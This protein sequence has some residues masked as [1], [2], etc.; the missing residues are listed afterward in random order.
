MSSF[1]RAAGKKGEE[2]PCS[3]FVNNDKNEKLQESILGNDISSSNN[4]NS[5]NGNKIISTGIPS[6][7]YILDEGLPQGSILVIIEDTPS[8]TFNYAS[9]ILKCF[10]SDG[11]FRKDNLVFMGSDE[12]LQGLYAP[13]KKLER[14]HD[15]AASKS[16]NNLQNF[17]SNH[18]SPSPS[19]SSNSVS[20]D[21]TESMDKME[22]AWRYKHISKVD[23]EI[24][25]K[26]FQSFSSIEKGSKLSFDLS[27]RLNHEKYILNNEKVAIVNTG[28]IEDISIL[29]KNRK[30]NDNLATRIA[31]HG[32]GSPS[33]N[34][35]SN[36]SLSS[37]LLSFS[38]PN[39]VELLDLKSEIYNSAS[40]CVIIVSMELLDECSLRNLVRVSD[41][42]IQ[43]VSF[44]K[45]NVN[46]KYYNGMVKLVKPLRIPG[47]LKLSS[48][49]D[50]MD[51]A[52]KCEKKRMIIEKYHLP[53]SFDDDNDNNKES[54]S[55]KGGSISSC[56]TAI[57]F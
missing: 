46:R 9:T 8:S 44:D 52:F 54:F 45:E 28:K 51:L 18:S 50:A 39:L 5:I 37:S 43:L 2:P 17:P 40:Y 12:I 14:S 1:V 11:I 19:N 15:I 31:I 29:L 53:P 56:G 32:L 30:R 36:S 13:I 23:S 57:D 42:A 26:N 4:R 20:D 7:D 3:T 49:S 38:F 55:K 41:C 25:I 6:L 48:S 16:Y 47:T 10:C 35:C 22:I 34:D 21:L 33:L 27:S 24:G